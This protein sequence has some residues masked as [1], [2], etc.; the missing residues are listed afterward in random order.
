M[1]DL[2]LALLVFCAAFLAY[3]SSIYIGFLSDEYGFTPIFVLSA[4]ELL[5]AMSRVHEGL[6]KL[7]PFRPATFLS[8]YIDYRL[9][10]FE[11]VPFHLVNVIIH[12][13]NAS[14]VYIATRML[15]RGKTIALVAALFFSAYPAGIEA[16]GWVSGRFELTCCMWIFIS[17][18]LWL[19]SGERRYFIYL[20][21]LAY[22]IA[23][24]CKEVA[25]GAIVVYFTLGLM[26]GKERKLDVL[27]WLLVQALALIIFFS[28][29]I[30]L[31]GSVA[32]DT[33]ATRGGIWIAMVP[34][35]IFGN[36][37]AN[38]RIMLTPFNRVIENINEVLLYWV[39]GIFFVAA[40]ANVL[41]RNSQEF[42][43]WILFGIVFIFS[44]IG[45]CLVMVPV[46]DSLDGSRFLY[47][48]SIGLGIILGVAVD[49]AKKPWRYAMFAPLIF[50]LIFNVVVLQH[51]IKNWIDVGEK[52]S[53]YDGIVAN[54]FCYRDQNQDEN[55]TLIIVNVPMINKGVHMAPTPFKPYINFLT[56][57]NIRDV[58][59]VNKG[60]D[61]LQGWYENLKNSRQR[62]L[63]FVLDR[64]SG[65]FYPLS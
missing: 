26:Y 25:I 12:S 22:L 29:R 44:F 28:F 30:W 55:L 8:F 46:L 53:Y 39:F 4:G 24:L 21:G 60:M 38:L 45:P 40:L 34:E 62:Y 17:I 47:F 31:F 20:S 58:M 64:D 7:H 6:I 33:F 65:E 5:E 36:L 32:G 37:G 51:N 2:Y 19:K 56:R 49:Q 59:Y 14:L 18:I 10:G 61:E 63:V 50:I 23:L 15:T 9:F 52:A 43:R 57:V 1:R 27:N 48:P 54:E 16:V 3:L 41:V 11:P 42:A 35:H 13:L